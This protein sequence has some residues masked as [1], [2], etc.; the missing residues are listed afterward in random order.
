MPDRACSS[1]TVTNS[2]QP[3]W[4]FSLNAPSPL[5]KIGYGGALPQAG[6]EAEPFRV[7]L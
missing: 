7:Y 6:R 5:T 2:I 3:G 4:R 1:P